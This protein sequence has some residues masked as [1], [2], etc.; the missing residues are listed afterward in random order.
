[1]AYPILIQIPN[2]IHVLTSRLNIRYKFM[3]T[4]DNGSS[5]TAGT[6]IL[7]WQWF[8]GWLEI[9]IRKI[10]RQIPTTI[11][12]ECALWKWS[13]LVRS[14]RQKNSVNTAK[15]RIVTLT[16]LNDSRVGCFNQ[17]KLK[18]WYRTLASVDDF[19]SMLFNEWLSFASSHL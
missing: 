12:I 8:F 18:S 5:G 17:F 6:F 10:S 16:M 19:L 3:N 2:R 13:Q 7:I 1:M 11:K 15:N 14:N 9:I 4:L